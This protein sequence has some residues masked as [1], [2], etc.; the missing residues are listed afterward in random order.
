MEI[1]IALAGL[2]GYTTYQLT[3]ALQMGPSAITNYKQPCTV[4]G[5]M[6]RRNVIY[7]QAIYNRYIQEKRLF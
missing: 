4:P 5:E 2:R 3:P 1:N 7:L 6:I